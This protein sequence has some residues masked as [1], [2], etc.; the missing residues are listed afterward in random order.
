MSCDVNQRCSSDLA[1]I[2]LRCGS[3]AAA[4]I[5]PLPWEPLYAVCVSHHPPKKKKQ[6]TKFQS[7]LCHS[8]ALFEQVNKL[9]RASMF[10]SIKWIMKATCL[11]FAVSLFSVNL[12]QNNRLDSINVNFLT[13][14][15]QQVTAGPIQFITYLMSLMFIEN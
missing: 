13:N 10:S 9:L 4:L 15:Q 1:L 5:R 2:W 6:K 12:T 8:K 7:H 14:G 3:A 11:S